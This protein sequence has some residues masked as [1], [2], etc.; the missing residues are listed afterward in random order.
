VK[1]SKL[2]KAAAG[3]GRFIGQAQRA[4]QRRRRVARHG[5]ELRAV[6]DHTARIRRDDILLVCCLRN[7][8][9]RLPFFLDYYRRLGVDHFLFIDNGSTDGFLEWLRPFEDCSAWQTGA[10]YLASDFGMQWCN[11][12]LHRYGDG[13]LCVTVDPDEF[14][15][16]PHMATRRLRELGTFLKDD[17]RHCMHV[18]MLD[19]YGS[20]LLAD[21]AYRS[22]DDPFQVCPYFDRDGYLQRPG[23]NGSTWIQGGPRL[24]VYNREEPSN[25]PALNKV[26]LVWWRRDFLYRSSM[27]DGYPA[28]LN[29]A[30]TPGEV[31]LTGCLFHFKFLSTLIEKAREEAHRNQHYAGGREYRSYREGA[32]VP[33]FRAGISVRYESPEQLVALGLM[34]AGGWI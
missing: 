2:A 28:L 31:S 34:N 27:H 18:L 8:L 9:V 21:A 22:G 10:S 6:Q 19:A 11:F 23:F 15:V 20:G 30:H 33:L 17:E 32:E 1:A 4:W 29:R 24:R 12:L 7:E 26:P 16:Y 13:H 3:A 14:L 5:R 25:A